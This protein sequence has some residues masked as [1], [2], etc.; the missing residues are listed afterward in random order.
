MSIIIHK[1]CGHL[2]YF[3]PPQKLHLF[4][5][6][7]GNKTKSLCS[8]ATSKCWPD[9]PPF[10][11]TLLYS[12]FKESHSQASDQNLNGEGLV[13]ERS[14]RP[15]FLGQRHQE[16]GVSR[17][18]RWAVIKRYQEFNWDEEWTSFSWVK[19]RSPVPAGSAAVLFQTWGSDQRREPWGRKGR[20]Y[21]GE[22]KPDSDTRARAYGMCGADQPQSFWR[23]RETLGQE[24]EGCR[25]LQKHA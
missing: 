3:C 19:W 15:R 5:T 1:S 10:L 25:I 17:K 22:R 7:Q 24:T 8:P 9:L 13:R 4:P 18:A 14:P 16:K 23:A 2:S 11:Y 12:V 6:T 20:F 21:S